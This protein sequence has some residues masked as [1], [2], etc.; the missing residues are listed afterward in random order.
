MS[1]TISS[2]PQPHGFI[3]DSGASDY[4]ALLRTSGGWVHTFQADVEVEQ[5]GG[6]GRKRLAQLNREVADWL[7]KQ[8]NPDEE[9]IR[10]VE[11]FVQQYELNL[12]PLTEFY[13]CFATDGRLRVEHYG[14][15]VNGQPPYSHRDAVVKVYTGDR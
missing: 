3:G 12:P 9:G 4:I 2:F 8:P 6:A 15:P 10:N 14:G 7:R 1:A 13:R 5:S 11:R